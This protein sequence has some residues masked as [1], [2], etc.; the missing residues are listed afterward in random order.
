MPSIDKTNIII[1]FVLTCSSALHITSVFILPQSEM[2]NIYTAAG[3]IAAALGAF[4]FGVIQCVYRIRTKASLP[5]IILSV[6]FLLATILLT[7]LQFILFLLLL[8]FTGSG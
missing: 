2:W 3:S 1:V 4:V 8:G 6:A 5:R 7:A